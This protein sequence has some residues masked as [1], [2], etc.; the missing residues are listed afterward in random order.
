MATLLGQTR[1]QVMPPLTHEEW[2]LARAD[3]FAFEAFRWFRFG[4]AFIFMTGILLVSGRALIIGLLALAEKLRP[5]PADHPEY[6]PEVTI[7]IPA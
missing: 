2:L 7:M 1:T 3:A 5:N 6:Q 4:I